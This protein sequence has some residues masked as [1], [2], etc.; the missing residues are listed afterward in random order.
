MNQVLGGRGAIEI[1]QFWQ[2]LTDE[3][4][5]HLRQLAQKMAATLGVSETITLQSIIDTVEKNRRQK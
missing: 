2:S 4:R 5:Q 3:Q 1:S